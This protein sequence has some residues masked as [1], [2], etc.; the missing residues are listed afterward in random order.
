MM[1]LD[2][3]SHNA[4]RNIGNTYIMTM[5]TLAK[6]KVLNQKVIILQYWLKILC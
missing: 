3:H 2:L 6:R 5:Y 4:C 1:A